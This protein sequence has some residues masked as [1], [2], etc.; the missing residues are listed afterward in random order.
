MEVM[1]EWPGRF[2]TFSINTTVGICERSS[3]SISLFLLFHSSG[4]PSSRSLL[5]IYLGL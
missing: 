1:R 5:S 3:V 4:R 2:S